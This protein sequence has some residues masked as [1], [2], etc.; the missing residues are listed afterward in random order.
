M[1]RHDPRH[2]RG[3]HRGRRKRRGGARRPSQRRADR[4]AL[5]ARSP[6]RGPSRHSRQQRGADPRRVAERGAVLGEA[7]GRERRPARR[8]PAQQPRRQLLRGAAA[9]RDGPGPGGVHVGAGRRALPVRGGLR[10]AQGQPGQVR[11][12]HGRR[13]PAVRRR[14]GV[15]LDGRR[16]DR[17]AAADHR[18]RARVR[19]PRRHRGN[20]GVHRARH[21]RAGRRPGCPR[22]QR[23]HPHRRGSGATVRDHRPGWPAAA[24]GARADVR[25]ASQLPGKGR[26]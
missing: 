21:R 22:G 11:R 13:L 12:R 19:L 4:G 8:R 26:R 14:R 2:R 6:G 25:G 15:D 24:V 10:R 7:A 20:A 18:Q 3:G 16:A 9:G 23:T 5:R 1:G 17:A